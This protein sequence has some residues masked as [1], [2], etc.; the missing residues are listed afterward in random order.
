MRKQRSLETEQQTE[1]RL[2]SARDA[3][4]KRRESES[5][6]SAER[7]RSSVRRG[8]KK[9]RAEESPESTDRR[10]ASVRRGMQTHRAEE[11]PESTDRRRAS[12]RHGMQRRRAEESP[13]S[14][15]RRRAS[16][17]QRMENNRAEN[18]AKDTTLEECRQIFLSKASEGP[19]Y[20][21]CSCLRLHY[22]SSVVRM[23]T[24]KYKAAPSTAKILKTEDHPMTH[25]ATWICNTCN[26]ALKAGRLPTQSWANDLQLDDIPPA[27]QG[28]RP[29][30]I[31]LI[32]QR[33]PFMKLVA[34]PRGGQKAIH[35]SAVN[36]PSK[37]QSI[38]TLLPR[39]PE[40]AEVFALKLKRKLAYKGHYMYEYVRPKHVMDA[41]IWL[42][43]HNPLYK[44]IEI[45]HDWEKQWR[46]GDGDLWEAITKLCDDDMETEEV[47]EDAVTDLPPPIPIGHDYQGI[48]SLARRNRFGFHN[49]PGDGNCFFHAVSASLSSAG[50]Q[51]VGGLELR[52]RLIH[53]LQT[54]NDK[55]EYMGFLQAPANPLYESYIRALI[56]GEWADN[57]AVQ[58]LADMLNI[59]ICVINTISQ[60]GKK[61]NLDKKI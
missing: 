33:I 52:E 61:Q 23:K 6:E 37:L 44:N 54:T 53:H 24:E 13:E 17:K 35:R 59:N 56:N 15:N 30:D 8:M 14:T 16:N 2:A 34:L 43:Q 19:I 58:A 12:V 5:L 41:L 11:S 55:N 39:L 51:P 21:C 48:V 3:V 32:S 38:T 29:L 50:V 26:N 57:L 28:L 46:E 36:V 45:C 10:R 40:T 47:T 49:V 1:A 31:R 60:D 18:T 22:R 25:D 27:L 20:A 42:K 7:R 4:R 9:R